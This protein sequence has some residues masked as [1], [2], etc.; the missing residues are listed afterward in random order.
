MNVRDLQNQ[1]KDLDPEDYV[2]MRLDGK[3]A[4]V[5]G[6]YETSMIADRHPAPGVFGAAM[7]RVD[8]SNV[9]NI[10]EIE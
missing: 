7:L 9:F 6:V 5:I 8:K 10:T 1:L 4:A 2:W 3:Y